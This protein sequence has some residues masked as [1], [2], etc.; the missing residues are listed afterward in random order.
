LYSTSARIET[1][2]H[3]ARYEG[4]YHMDRRNGQGTYWYA[5]GRSYSGEYKDD[6]PNG[7][8]KQTD[9]DGSVL[10]DGE[11]NLGEFING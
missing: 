10:Y 5:D 1:W 6:R 4:E 7:Q 3:G 8:G 9:S 11:W 2:P